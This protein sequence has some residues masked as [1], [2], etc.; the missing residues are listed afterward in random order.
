MSNIDD[1]FNSLMEKN[2]RNNVSSE[3]TRRIEQM[4]EQLEESKEDIIKEVLKDLEMVEKMK[5]EEK[6]TY[7][8]PE[9]GRAHV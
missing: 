2:W 7:D 3:V 4:F 6:E 8:Y 1:F 5:V 9:I